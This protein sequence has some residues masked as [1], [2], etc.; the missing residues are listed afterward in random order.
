MSVLDVDRLQV[1]VFETGIALLRDITL[2]IKP[3]SIVGLVGESGSGKSMFSLALMGLL[4]SGVRVTSG[5]ARV[6]GKSILKGLTNQ[7]VNS[8]REDIALISQNPR[9]ALN[10]TMRINKQVIRVLRQRCNMT[11]KEARSEVH[12]L[13]ARVGIPDVGRV[14]NSYPHQ[15]SGGMCQRVVIGM[16]LSTRAPL[17][18]AD[19]PTTG[20]DVT[21]QAQILMLLRKLVGES[22]EKSVMM[23]THDLAVV[24][25]M[26][27]QLIVLY[28][29]QVMEVGP[30]REVFANP[31]H[32]YTKFLLE[33]LESYADG[34]ADSTPSVSENPIDFGLSGCRFSNRCPFSTPVCQTTPPP[35]IADNTRIAY[36]HNLE[37]I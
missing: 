16:A 21:I 11:F 9:A 6:A 18:I 29:G 22:D 12:E 37:S 1:E 4:P 17:L 2:S 14:A 28:G 34:S 30:T 5:K 26:C 33:S 31:R 25:S 23:V 20:L 15:L 7:Y 3:G 10:P 27:D 32:P 35:A 8:S 13:L 19:E 36:C 24:S